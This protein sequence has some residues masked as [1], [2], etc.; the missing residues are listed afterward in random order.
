[1]TKKDKNSLRVNVYA[2]MR[3]AV[4]SGVAMG[5]RH[6]H[7]HADNPSEDV[8]KDKIS[9]DVMNEICEWFNF[10]DEEETDG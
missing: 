9:D 3:Q 2:V 1:M 10:N 8:I 5:W 6:A 7:K 4:E